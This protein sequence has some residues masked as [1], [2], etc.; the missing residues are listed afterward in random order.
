MT[1]L[2]IGISGKQGA[3]KSTLAQALKDHFNREPDWDADIY[4]FAAPLYAIQDYI[5]KTIGRNPGIKDGPLLQ[6]IGQ[7]GR[8]RHGENIW[9]EAWIEAA[10]KHFSKF[11]NNKNN[12]VVIV[13]DMRYPNE[14]LTLRSFADRTN[15][16]SFLVRLECPEEMRKT[17]IKEYW[18]ENTGHSSE[19]GLDNSDH[20]FDY[21]IGNA[22][23]TPQLTAA[24]VINK[25]RDV[26][27]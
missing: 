1:N 24:S 14:V 7:W 9:T 12:R 21:T 5:Y 6:M 3:G 25:I 10:S 18:R 22:F 4:K 11:N 15:S 13:D 2:V 16:S 27:L 23:Y 8:E 17:R 19:T 20:L 26:K